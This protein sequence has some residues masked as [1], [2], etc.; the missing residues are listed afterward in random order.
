MIRPEE[1]A[2]EGKGTAGERNLRQIFDLWSFLSQIKLCN[3]P[4]LAVLFGPPQHVDHP[5]NKCVAGNLRLSI[6]RAQNVAL[7]VQFKDSMLIPLTKINN[8]PVVAE[9]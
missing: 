6:D 9:I 5:I 2:I 7:R 8:S 3:C 4:A 1:L